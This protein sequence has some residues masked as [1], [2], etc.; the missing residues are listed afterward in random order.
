MSGMVMLEQ[1]KIGSSGHGGGSGYLKS[2]F[3]IWCR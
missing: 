2:R 1:I 3:Q